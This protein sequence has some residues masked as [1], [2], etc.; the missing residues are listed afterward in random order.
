M[1]D[2]NSG[3]ASGG[4]FCKDKLP[5]RT[6]SRVKKKPF[7]VPPDEVS[8]VISAAGGLLTGTP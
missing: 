8:P 1:A 7:P 2:E 3:D 4:D 6:L 5:L